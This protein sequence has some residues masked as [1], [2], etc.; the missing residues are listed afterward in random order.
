MYELSALF[1]FFLPVS[2]FDD[3]HD[4]EQLDVI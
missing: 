4:C 3:K 1:F 2:S